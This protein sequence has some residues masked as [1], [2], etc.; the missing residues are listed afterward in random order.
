VGA[1]VSRSTRSSTSM[2]DE[3]EGRDIAQPPFDEQACASRTTTRFGIASNVTIN[4][5]LVKF[6]K[7]RGKI[8]RHFLI[9][10]D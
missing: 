2:E 4:S 9:P 1:E 8:A 7:S 5:A 3:G 10:L 6:A